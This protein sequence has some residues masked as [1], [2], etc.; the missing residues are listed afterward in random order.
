MGNRQIVE[1]YAR[2]L[3]E[4]D[5]DAQDALVHDD[6]VACYP[7]SEKFS[8]VGQTVVRSWRTIPVRRPACDLQPTGSSGGTTNSSPARRGTSST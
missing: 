8:A 6:Y 5:L 7:Q 2:A 1:R 3:A 4:N